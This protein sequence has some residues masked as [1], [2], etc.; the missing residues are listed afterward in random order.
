[1]AHKSNLYKLDL[2]SM[3]ISDLKIDNGNDLWD[4]NGGDLYF[5]ARCTFTL[6]KDTAIIISN[7]GTFTINLITNRLKELENGIIK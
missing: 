6:Y 2:L 3:V 7:E 5:D 4:N 1:M